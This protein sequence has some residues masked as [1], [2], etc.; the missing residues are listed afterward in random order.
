MV[1]S[2]CSTPRHGSC[3]GQEEYKS[4]SR[5]P[6]TPPS[7]G[8]AGRRTGIASR[9]DLEAVG[10]ASSLRNQLTQSEERLAESAVKSSGCK[11]KYTASSQS[12]AFGASA[13]RLRW[14]SKAFRIA[15]RLGREIAS[16]R[17]TLDTKRSAETKPRSTSIPSV[18]NTP[19]RSARKGRSKRYR[20]A[21]YSTESV[22]RLFQSGR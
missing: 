9:G 13:A 6:R 17:E 20:R 10:T 21:G 22:R 11:R 15:Q 16:L 14:N 19:R 7:I 12:E 1:T 3:H 18:R 2:K 8:A 4:A 5:K